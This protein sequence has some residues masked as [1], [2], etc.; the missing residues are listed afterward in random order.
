MDERNTVNGNLRFLG[1]IG[2]PVAQAKSPALINAALR[3]RRITDTLMI[4]L[5]VDSAGLAD[6]INGLKA[7]RNFCGAVVTMPHKR[8]VLPLLDRVSDSAR[9]IGACNVFKRAPD[10]RLSGTMMDGE[11]FVA[12]LQTRGYG[13]RGKSVYLAG[14]GG[15]AAAIA[16]AVAAHGARRLVIF[17]RTA[18]KASALCQQLRSLYPGVLIEQGNEFPREVDIAINGT[19]VGMSGDTAQPFSLRYLDASTV[20]CDIVVFPEQTPLLANAAQAGLPVHYGKEMIMA[21]VPLLIDF[22][23]S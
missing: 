13:I 6:A 5:H 8:N 11:G 21:Q 22:M 12:G 19:S 3:E 1:I 20:V 16:F 23:L 10:G 4:P 17:N 14:A 18:G 7:C 9:A 2:D 15:A